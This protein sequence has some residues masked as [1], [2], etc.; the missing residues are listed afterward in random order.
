MVTVMRHSWDG[1]LVQHFINTLTNPFA[2]RGPGGP[3]GVRPEGARRAVSKGGS[4]IRFSRRIH[5]HTYEPEHL[6]RHR[7]A[8][9]AA[10][11][12]VG[13]LAV[14]SPAVGQP[15]TPPPAGSLGPGEGRRLIE[16]IRIWKMTE[17]LNLNEEQ[18]VKLFP[19]M[20]QLEA[21]RREFHNRQRLLREE[22]AELLKQR[23]LRDQDIKMKLEE[24]ERI[25]AE[26]KG[27]ERAVK[28]E[29]RSILSVEQQARLA[30]FEE[31]FDM[32]MRR[33][34]QDLRQR[35]PGLSPYG[36]AQPFR[37][38]GVRD[39]SPLPVEG[40]PPPR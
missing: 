9:L 10:A 22:L 26:F 36:P 24:L 32:E 5:R 29:L 23:P 31:R 30:L 28:N 14:A 33:T 13:A 4:G 11:G 17:A 39:R 25:D 1:T 3:S 20:T 18:A 21:S 19:K 8:A 15:F 37:P 38:P 34:I 16:T 2:L 35:R 12:L 7:R 6:A 27:R 40:G